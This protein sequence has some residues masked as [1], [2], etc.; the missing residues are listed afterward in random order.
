M[1]PNLE[2]AERGIFILNSW[3][4]GLYITR[5]NRGHFFIQLTPLVTYG[6]CTLIGRVRVLGT[7][8]TTSS[9]MSRVHETE[10]PTVPSDVGIA[11]E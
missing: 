10:G 8:N 9:T 4:S 1:G 3:L 11:S 7:A 2:A 5:P 6:A